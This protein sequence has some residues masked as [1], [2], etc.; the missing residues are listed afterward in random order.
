MPFMRDKAR[1]PSAAPT[2]REIYANVPAHRGAAEH[3]LVRGWREESGYLPYT[4]LQQ[5]GGQLR[6]CYDWP[7]PSR[8]LQTEK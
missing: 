4:S 3:V 6:S 1:D 2:Q 8:R 7:G 5:L